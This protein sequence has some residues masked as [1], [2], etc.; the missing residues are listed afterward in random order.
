[1]F[2]ILE[3]RQGPRALGT[4]RRSHGRHR[5]CDPLE[6]NWAT[7]GGSR[8]RAGGDAHHNVVASGLLCAPRAAPAKPDQ[9]GLASPRINQPD[10]RAPGGLQPHVQNSEI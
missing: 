2:A 8:I 4:W 9:R 6:L 7:R 3:P 1:M 5:R 10:M